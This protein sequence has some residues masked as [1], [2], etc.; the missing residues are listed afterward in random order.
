M[1]LVLDTNVLISGLLSA[2]NPPGRIVDSIRSGKLS[3]VVDDRILAEY[4][5]VLRRPLFDRY[6][7]A[8]ERDWII[9]F[10]EI[11]SRR[12]IAGPRIVSLP[13]PNDACFIEI[14]A[15]A[16][17]PF[18]TGNLKHYPEKSRVGV[19]VLSPRDFVDRWK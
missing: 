1:E 11:E 17:L 3:L 10:L 12:V 6:L 19:I 8:A 13:D 7:T 2:R 14:A 15:E 9:S 5:T 18:V 16:G 4:R